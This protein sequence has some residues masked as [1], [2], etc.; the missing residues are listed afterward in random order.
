MI[1]A[2]GKAARE[3]YELFGGNSPS[4]IYE[5]MINAAPQVAEQ[6]NQQEPK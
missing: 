2:G 3:Y 6:T 1:K 5:A 4:I